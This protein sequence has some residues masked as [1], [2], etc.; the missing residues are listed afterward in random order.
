MALARQKWPEASSNQLLQLMVKTALN[1]DKQWNNRTGYGAI[2]LS[3]LVNT[4]PSQYP[5]ENPIAQKQGGSSPTVEEVQQYSNGLVNP[6]GIRLASAYTY[7]GADDSVLSNPLNK[8]PVH[9][10][11]SPAY[12]RK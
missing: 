5:D 7:R 11:T 2:S 1:P 10:G 3:D 6:T 12:H 9:L 4:D 8:T